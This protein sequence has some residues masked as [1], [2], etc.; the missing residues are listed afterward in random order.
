MED[1]VCDAP[2]EN[3]GNPLRNPLLDADYHEAED[4]LPIRFVLRVAVVSDL[5]FNGAVVGAGA[6]G[7]R[8]RRR[9][10]ISLLDV[11]G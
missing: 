11:D 5:W 6:F 3:L 10:H 1:G 8:S 7:G 4:V 2:P 9:E